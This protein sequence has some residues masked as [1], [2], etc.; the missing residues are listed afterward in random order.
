M[1]F[2]PHLL[3]NSI[4][5]LT[6]PLYLL[7][8][9]F[10][11]SISFSSRRTIAPIIAGLGSLIRL[12]GLFVMSGILFQYI[13]SKRS[14]LLY[15]GVCIAPIVLFIIL[16]IPVHDH[17]NFI[18]MKVDHEILVLK[19]YFG[20]SVS[21][22]V[23]R[24]ANSFLYLGWST[25]PSFIA[26]IPFGLFFLY[27]QGK[28]KLVSI[29]FLMGIMACSG[30]LA[31]LRAYDTRYFM[32]LYPMFAM[33]S[34][35]GMQLITE[36]FGRRILCQLKRRK[37]RYAVM[38]SAAMVA[39]CVGWYWSSSWYHSHYSLSDEYGRIFP[40][41]G[42]VVVYPTFT[43]AA[44]EK[45]AFYTYYKGLCDEICLTV[46]DRY[47]E[48][49]KEDL[50]QYGYQTFL[51]LGYHIITDRD[52]TE[53]PGILRQYHTVI[54]LHNEYVTLKEFE[55]ITSHPNVIYLYPNALYARVNLDDLNNIILVRGHNYPTKDIANGF[56]WM[57]DNSALEYAECEKWSFKK[58]SNGYQ[59]NCYPE[60]IINTSEP[61]WEDIA[62]L[63]NKDWDQTS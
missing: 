33:L 54:V 62:N 61:L 23:Y 44:Y 29:L 6:E 53:N 41:D 58:I 21:Y 60:N 28:K 10:A 5:G 59:L 34:S 4:L 17:T 13:I 49:K 31:Y 22:G 43:L 12:E 38:I 16:N 11:L 8:E 35:L 3:Q 32:Q 14:P 56:S 45:G 7:I 27:R 1:A 20:D 19:E 36:R 37:I 15:T 46:Y 9:T 50:T 30:L 48:L 47:N 57:D 55:A 2:E 25:W 42:V 39:L 52:V 63:I 26:L 40:T 51:K 18:K 24:L